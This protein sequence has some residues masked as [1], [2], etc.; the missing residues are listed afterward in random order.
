MI[1][2]KNKMI[3]CANYKNKD[4]VEEVEIRR[5]CRE[6]GDYLYRYSWCKR[7]NDIWFA[8][9]FSKVAVFFL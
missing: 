7:V 2:G 4:E 9:G 6:V 1:L 5:L 3:H 8:G